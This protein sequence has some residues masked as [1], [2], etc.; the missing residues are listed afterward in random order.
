MKNIA[1]YK[2][3]IAKIIILTVFAVLIYAFSRY[4]IMD[5]PIWEN[6]KR[7]RLVI[8]MLSFLF[9]EYTV[10]IGM[11]NTIAFYELFYKLLPWVILVCLF[12]YIPVKLVYIPMLLPVAAVLI[13]YDNVIAVVFHAFVVIF[14]YYIEFVDVDILILYFWF[15]IFV[16]FLARNV[17]SERLKCIYKLIITTVVYFIISLGYQIMIF[18]KINIKVILAG[19]VPLIVSVFPI[20]FK[21]LLRD[22]NKVYLKKSLVKINDDENELLLILMD[23]NE[24]S[25]FHSLRVADVAVKIA[26]ELSADVQLVKAGARFHEIGKIESDDYIAAGVRIMKKN[27]FPLEVI[28]IVKEHNSK[29]NIPKT[30]ESAIV[31]L[32]DSVETT[33]GSIIETR[34]E[35]FNQK[36]IVENVID[37]RFDSGMLDYAVTDIR[38]FKKLRKAYM[39]IYAEKNN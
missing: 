25:Y 12:S 13:A 30:M 10:Y 1:K 11:K 35:N 18:D 33:I 20:Y 36:K 21:D 5:M 27:H 7:S 38:K 24:N 19:I 28:K 34:G 16:Y 29:S 15:F 32:T 4:K 23:K 17:K 8:I 2:N 26:K 9:M 6:E 31:M 14:Y 37:I 3:L 39:D 22:I